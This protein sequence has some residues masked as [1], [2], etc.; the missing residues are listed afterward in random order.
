MDKWTWLVKGQYYK[1][2]YDDDLDLVTTGQSSCSGESEA[3]SH[4]ESVPHEMIFWKR[5]E[6]IL[7]SSEK[8]ST[9]VNV[10]PVCKSC[11]NP[12]QVEE[13]KDI[14]VGLICFLKIVFQNEKYLKSTIKSSVN[15]SNKNGQFF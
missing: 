7:V 5:K 6:N 15:M 3:E 12:I 1:E 13:E 2:Y 4:N 14:A 10:F 9:F 11:N 8:V